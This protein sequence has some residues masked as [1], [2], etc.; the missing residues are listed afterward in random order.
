MQHQTVTEKNLESFQILTNG[1]TGNS[2]VGPPM[3]RRKKLDDNDAST[4]TTPTE[5][6][7]GKATTIPLKFWSITAT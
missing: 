2:G 7:R 4:T 1:C 3:T 5:L 6:W